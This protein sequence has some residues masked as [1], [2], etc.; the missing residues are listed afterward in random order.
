MITDVPGVRVGH[1]TNAAARTGCTVVLP[2]P[3][4]VASGEIRGGAPAERDF[5][6]LAPERSVERVD[7]VVLSGGS[8]YGLAAA[9]G[10][11]R[12]C[13]EQRIGL[14]TPVGRVPI[15][16]GL[17]IFDLLVAEPGIRPSADDGY[18][19][20]AAA[21]GDAQQ[22]GPVGAGAGASVGNWRGPA[23]ARPAGLGSASERSGDLVV[24]VLAVVNAFGDALQPRDERPD[25]DEM[26]VLPITGNTTLA[27]VATNARLP[28]VGCYLAA[29]SAHDGFARALEPAH[30]TMDGDAAVV[31][32][33]GE[34]DAPLEAVRLLTARTVESA[35]RQAL[36]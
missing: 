20:C 1:F 6:L 3:G 34:A 36:A 17:S 23:H 10:A 18:A 8:V 16:V 2:P 27:V 25:V 28:K 13:E 19:A 14:E 35:V 7:A 30:T 4:V 24:G 32:A 15:V 9:D 11:L 26:Q 29:Q 33:T 12:W 5:A 31:F 21:T 22:T